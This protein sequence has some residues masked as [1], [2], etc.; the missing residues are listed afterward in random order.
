M[1]FFPLRASLPAIGL[2]LSALSLFALAP[3]A[4]RAAPPEGKIEPKSTARSEADRGYALF[5]SGQ[6]VEATLAF[7]LA[8]VLFHAPTLV[9]AIARSESK[10]GHLLEARAL[11]KQVIA[12][13][14]SPGA[15][16]EYRG[17]QESSVSELAAVEARIPHLWIT[18]H[19]AA[20]RAYAVDVDDAEID[21][22]KLLKP[23]EIDPGPH[24]ITVRPDRGASEKRSVTLADGASEAMVIELPPPAADAPLNIPP[25]PPKAASKPRDLL[26]PALIGVGAGALGLGVGAALG[27]VTLSK[28]SAIRKHCVDDL[29]PREQESAAESARTTA[30]ISTVAF[31][32]G[33]VLA[34]AGVTLLVLRPK[35]QR[36]SPSPS[37][38]LS[39]GPGAL[40]ARGAF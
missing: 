15:P 35:A 40:F 13:K 16:P 37:I 3:E 5:E 27:V 21:P 19:G 22:G 23:F 11:F 25:P 24:R 18:V 28:T 29:C 39:I 2:G 31:V 33:G 34:A 8:E 38:G 26:A 1:A 10:L 12:E 6:F 4:A 9:F 7:R 17:A 14:L 36:P 32:A 30:T 20:G